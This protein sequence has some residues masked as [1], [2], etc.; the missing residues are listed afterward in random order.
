M[1]AGTPGIKKKNEKL[2]I[3][4]YTKFFMVRANMRV[5]R[6]GDVREMLDGLDSGSTCGP[7]LVLSRRSGLM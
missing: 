2:G 6:H 3:L 5:R 1:H 7:W 4:R